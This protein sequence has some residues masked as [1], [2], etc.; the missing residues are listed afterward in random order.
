M[1]KFPK[2]SIFNILRGFIQNGYYFIQKRSF[3]HKSDLIEVQVFG[4]EVENNFR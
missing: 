2:D 4:V 1:A 3:N